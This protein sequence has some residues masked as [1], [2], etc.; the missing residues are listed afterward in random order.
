MGAVY[1]RT[2]EYLG[3]TDKAIIAFRRLMIQGAKALRDKGELPPTVDNAALY[4]ARG[5]HAM[6]PKDINWIEAS[7]P[8]RKAFSEGVPEEFRA[9]LGNFQ[10][11]QA[12]AQ[13]IRT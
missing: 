12:A 3:T 8:W 10:R 2:K 7:E 9:Q 4:R 5:F 6:L 1:D 11:G 13:P